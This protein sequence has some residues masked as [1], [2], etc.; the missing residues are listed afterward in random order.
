M[1]KVFLLLLVFVAVASAQFADPVAIDNFNWNWKHTGCDCLAVT[2][3]VDTLVL[4]GKT[5]HA[6]INPISGNVL[7]KM[8][9]TWDHWWTITEGCTKSYSGGE[10]DTLFLKAPSSTSIVQ[11]EHARFLP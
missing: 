3:A 1:K 9:A 4:S 2:T 11:V 10:L 7:I 6:A 8:S 5:W